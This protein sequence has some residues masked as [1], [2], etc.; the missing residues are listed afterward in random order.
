MAAANICVAFGGVSIICSLFLK[1]VKKYMTDHI[2]V[3]I[4]EGHHHHDHHK[5]THPVV[6]REA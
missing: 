1:D 6:Q 3:H 2:A 5:D 4:E